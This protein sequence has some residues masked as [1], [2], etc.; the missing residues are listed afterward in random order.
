MPIPVKALLRISF[1]P[2]VAGGANPVYA[3]CMSRDLG[4]TGNGQKSDAAAPVLGEIL[5]RA[6]R[7]HEFSL[8]DV[9]RRTR[10]PN[11]HLSQ[12][13][14]G[15]I[16]RPDPAIVFEL[17]SLYRLDFALL[18]QWAGYVGEGREVTPGLLELLVRA[19]SELD[20]SLQAEAL[21]LVEALRVDESPT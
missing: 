11:A 14:R 19:F 17:A 9:E 3:P 6:R 20:P 12:I 18:A 8:R 15:V 1:A 13:E 2:S 7:H 10:I 16:R 5:K 21:K 4:E